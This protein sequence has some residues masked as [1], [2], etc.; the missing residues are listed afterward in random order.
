MAREYTIGIPIAT[1]IFLV[2]T[3]L[4]YRMLFTSLPNSEELR[5]E[6]VAVYNESRARA[7]AFIPPSN[8]DPMTPNLNVK[9]DE[10]NVQLRVYGLINPRKQDR[11]VEI[12][13]GVRKDLGSRPVVVYFHYPRAAPRGDDGEPLSPTVA[14]A[15]EPFR[16]E[17]LAY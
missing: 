1:V 14:T 13:R 10:Q 17:R 16:I 5:Q 3:V 7:V 2:L 6:A 11:F 15:A 9:S 12:V 4:A 8:A